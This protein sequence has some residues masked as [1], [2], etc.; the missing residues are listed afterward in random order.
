MK[1]SFQID[2]A[3]LDSAQSLEWLARTLAKG[4]LLGR[5]QSNKLGSGMEFSQ[6]RPY[7]QGDDLR[8]LDW[9]MYAKT[10]KYFI[11]QSTV[12]TDHQLHIHIDNSLSMT[13]EENGLSKLDLTKILTA[14]LSYVM[15]QQG[16][17]FSWYSGTFQFTSAQSLK[18]WRH[19][20]T[21]LYDIKTSESSHQTPTNQSDGVLLWMTDLYDTLD[22]I[23]T[24]ID[25]FLGPSKELVLF[26]II[27]QK[28]EELD[29]PKNASFRDLETQEQIP[30][31]AKA[32]AKSYKIA[33]GQ[34]IHMVKRLCAN[35]GAIYQK[36]YLQDD[37][38]SVLRHFIDQYHHLSSL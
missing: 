33:L 11:R 1:S 2:L 16:D 29:F 8:L 6:Y 14:A 38:P 12:E 9:R 28:E 37:I 5:H 27:G 25:S 21:L 31:N 23:E 10:G 26:H 22:Q 13:Y 24:Q 7:T 19:S 15:V 36:I 4:L 20:L 30:L 17:Q 35:K 34:H 3:V 18:D 32:Y